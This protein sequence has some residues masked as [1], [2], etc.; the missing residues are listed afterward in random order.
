MPK[1]RDLIYFLSLELENVRCFGNPAPILDLSNGGGKPAQWTLLL[2]DNGLGKTTL[3][4]SLI[5]TKFVPG[6]LPESSHKLNNTD[7]TITKGYIEPSLP[8][9]ENEVIERFIRVS[10]NHLDL[11]AKFS[12]GIQ[13][14]RTLVYDKK[15]VPVEQIKTGIRVKFNN[16]KL[17]D[18]STDKKENSK[19]EDILGGEYKE[20]FILTYGATR[21]TGSQS[22]YNKN[23]K[24]DENSLSFILAS[25]LFEK[26]VL[27][28]A[29][30]ILRFFELEALKAKRPR[31][32]SK[33]ESAA[34][35]IFES[36]K[37]M[38]IDILP[39]NEIKVKDLNFCPPPE[40]IC[41]N[42]F[43]GRNIPFSSLSLGYRTTINL[44]VDIGWQLYQY[45]P[46]SNDPLK[47]SAIILIDELDL[48]LHPQWQ[49]VI[50]DK[51]RNIFPNVQF[52]AT[53][54]SPLMV[55]SAVNVNLAVLQRVSDKVEIQNELETVYGWRVD[56]LRVDQIL[57]SPIFGIENTRGSSSEALFSERAKLL[58]KSSL[59][60]RDKARLTQI[61]KEIDELPAVSSMENMDF[62][63][64]ATELL[65]RGKE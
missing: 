41:L 45:Y 39:N 46:G 2:G 20:P 28:N 11:R 59:T 29:E 23:D 19:I 36:F 50:I 35:I 62:L 1:K 34:E 10:C 22:I 30:E 25:R 60:S 12:Q 43:S 54:H 37:K 47:E 65:E 26:T 24:M 13:L 31:T 44:I 57:N 51:L 27:Y 32:K 7:S 14:G 15:T 21:S 56:Q 4:E 58:K 17:S 3:L 18:Y 40:G 49:R 48:H 42:T 8:E 9:A 16:A 53:T 52:I 61:R 33:K 64:R 55:Q 5:W 6:A 38:V 63:R